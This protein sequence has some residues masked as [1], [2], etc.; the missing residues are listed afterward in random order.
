MLK[1]PSVKK[2]WLTY[3]VM[4]KKLLKSHRFIEN[5]KIGFS[6]F[7]FLISIWLYGYFINV[8]STKGY[9]I[10]VEK[11]KLSEIKFKNEIE[12]IDVKKLEWELANKI[13]PNPMKD[14]DK[15]WWKII[16][17]KKNGQVAFRD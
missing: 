8:S 17:I 16:V 12:K 2:M 13:A 5:L 11:E 4:K 15:L 6:A 7:L 10:K 9:F 3:I 1:I 14:Q